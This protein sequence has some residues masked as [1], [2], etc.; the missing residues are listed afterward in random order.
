M[1]LLGNLIHMVA[2]EFTVLIHSLR[3]HVP[4]A[5]VLRRSLEKLEGENTVRRELAAGDSPRVVFDRYGIL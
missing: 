4:S 3:R 1:H 2:C 5:E